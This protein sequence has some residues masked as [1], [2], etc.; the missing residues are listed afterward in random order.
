[1]E[2]TKTELHTHLVGM[3]SAEEFAE[4]IIGCGI[5]NFQFGDV[6]IS[7]SVLLKNDDYYSG[8]QVKKDEKVPYTKMGTYYHNRTEILKSIVN[9]YARINNISKNAAA[10]Y[11]Y[12]KLMNDSLR[13]LIKQGVEYVEISYSFHDR[14]S[15]F[16]IDEDI[17]DKIKCK[18]LLS[19]QRTTPATSED[20]NANT[21]EKAA[22]NLAKVLKTGKCVGFDIMGE[23]TKLRDEELDYAD[24]CNSFMV[25]LE[26][27]FDTL[28]KF[29]NTTLRIHSGET[30]NSF[31][32]TIK[33]LKMIGEVAEKRKIIIPPPEIRI[34]HGLYF[35]PSQEYIDLLKKF[36]CII[37]INASSNIKLSNVESSKSIPYNFYLDN[38]IPIVISTDA[39]GLWYTTIK[40]EDMIAERM[41]SSP[42]KYDTIVEIDRD[43]LSKKGR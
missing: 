3:L 20:P 1:M 37:E 6:R 14:I 7:P 41:V 40:K 35:D 42:Q 24:K 11:I 36:G 27:L 31:D 39:H 34:G 26:I 22:K 15:N 13:S 12:N 5:Y 17:K 2:Y 8:I 32:N 38:D 21:F 33:I 43:L 28:L 18:F 4:F 29:D 23:E 19:T 9:E 10:K 25:K 30:S 16:Q